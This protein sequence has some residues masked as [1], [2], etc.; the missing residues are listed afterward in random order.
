MDPLIIALITA[1]VLG[2]V[3]LISAFIRQILLSRDKKLNDEAQSSAL[4]RETAELEKIRTQMQNTPRFDAHYQILGKNKDEI[5][6]IDIQIEKILDKKMEV[7][8]RYAK[9]S[10]Q[11]SGNIVNK[12]EIS[13]ERKAVCD[14][15]R[16]EID[17]KIVFYD[18][19]LKQLQKRR[20]DLWDAHTKFE[21]HLLA[22]EKSRNDNL[23]EVYKQH[24][25]LLEKIY[26]RHIENM[27]VFSVK[28]IDASTMSFKDMLM[29]PIQ[30]LAQVFGGGVAIPF[31]NISLVQTRVEHVSRMDVD[32][33]QREINNPQFNKEPGPEEI[34]INDLETQTTETAF[35]L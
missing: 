29:V 22:Q 32:R 21:H 5:K 6:D 24:S 18:S 30:F 35:I 23:D 19:E 31:S 8:E 28:S 9:I 2:T 27:E 16:E 15:L 4:A 13:V 10:V 26:L 3:M 20:S 33:A 17:Y 11:E 1:A 34:D 12:G 7:V 25:A 14:K